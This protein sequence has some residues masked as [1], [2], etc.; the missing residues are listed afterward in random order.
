MYIIY[1][2][3]SVVPGLY[4]LYFLVASI[5]VALTGGLVTVISG[6]YAYLSDT[7]TADTRAF[8]YV[9]SK[10]ASLIISHTFLASLAE[11]VLTCIV[12]DARLSGYFDTMAQH[13]CRLWWQ[14]F[15][16]WKVVQ[17]YQ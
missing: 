14:E 15:Y 1:I 4:P 5:P 17:I 13:V 2:F 12:N 8:R 11:T 7:T 6:I 9:L 10:F 16:I 3:L